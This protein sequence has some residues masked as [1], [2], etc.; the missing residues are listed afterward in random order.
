MGGVVKECRLVLGAA[1][2]DI[3]TAVYVHQLLFVREGWGYCKDKEPRIFQNTV[4]CGAC[5]DEFICLEEEIQSSVG[6]LVRIN[7]TS[8][9]YDF[10]TTR[11]P[12]P[13]I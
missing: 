3:L 9:G 4:S 13:E 12:L 8:R 2:I 7:L 1:D 10:H 5:R 11:V 6:I